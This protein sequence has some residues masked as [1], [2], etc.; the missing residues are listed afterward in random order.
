MNLVVDRRTRLLAIKKHLN[1]T[2]FDIGGET[3]VLEKEARQALDLEDAKKYYGAS[4]LQG[5]VRGF[6]VRIF[7]KELRR[8]LHALLILQ[9]VLRGKLGRMRWMREYW[10]SISVVKSLE[11][12]KELIKRST[13][14]RD[15]AQWKEYFDPMTE[16]FWYHEGK[17]NLSTWNVPL[18]FQKTLVCNWEGFHDYGGS[19]S[20]TRCRCIF[21]NVAEYHGHLRTA[22][23]WFCVSCFKCN[24]G[25]VFPRCALCG[26]SKSEDGKDGEKALQDSV[27]AVRNKVRLFLAKENSTKTGFK[28]KLR[29][30]LVS[31]AV[32]I[33]ARKN[34]NITTQQDEMKLP[35]NIFREKTDRLVPLSTSDKNSVTPAS[36]TMTSTAGNKARQ[37]K[38]VS[39]DPWEAG[40]DKRR[41]NILRM[42]GC[43]IPAQPLFGR[44]NNKECSPFNQFTSSIA[45]LAA[46]KFYE[47]ELGGIKGERKRFADP[48]E[49]KGEIPAPVFDWITNITLDDDVRLGV[50]DVELSVPADERSTNM[51]DASPLQQ[52]DSNNNV[53]VWE[54]DVGS[55][56]GDQEQNRMLV[57][58]LFLAGQ[59]SKS[60]CPRAHPGLR[61]RAQIFYIRL[62]GRAKKSPF[63]KC[64][65]QYSGGG[66]NCGCKE[67]SNCPFYHIYMRP[68]TQEIIRRIYPI[69]EG[70]KMKVLPSGAQI[71]GNL[72]DNQLSGYGVMTWLSGASYAGDW[73]NDVR[74]GFGIYRTLQ[75]TEY[76]GG[77]RDGKRH[78][79]GH[80][81]N[82]LGEEYIG[83]WAHG[84][85]EGAGVLSGANGDSYTG[86]FKGHKFHGVGTFVKPCGSIFT[87]HCVEGM[88]SGL[89]IMV[90][91]TGEK[92]KGNFD[93]N[94]RHGKGACSYPNGSFY[95]GEWYRGVPTGFG[96]FIAPNGEKFVGQ[97]AGGRKEG[98]GRYMFLDG[99][100][101]DGEFHKD[102]AKGMGLYYAA[103]GDA[104]SGEWDNDKRHGRGTY[105][106]ANGS[107]YTGNWVENNIHGKGKFDF[108]S[109]SH[110]RGEFRKN[111][112]HGRGIYTWPN[113]NIYKG[114]FV[115]E[116]M[117][118]KGEMTYIGGHR[119]TGDWFNSKKHG[120]GTFYYVTGAV[121][122][123]DWDND[124]RRG[125]GRLT[126]L[127]GSFIEEYYDGEWDDD[128][129]HG[130]GTYV[131]RKDEG[132]VYS[133]DWEKGHRHGNGK[134]AFADGSFYSGSFQSEKM[135]G[136]GLYVGADGSQYT[137]EWFDNMRQGTGTMLGSDGSI[138]HGL[139]H[140]NMKHGH[141]RLQ[142]PDGNI[143]EGEWC[144]NI[145]VGD[146]LSGRYTLV[147]G[148]G[149][150]GGPSEITMQ[151]FSY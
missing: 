59:C 108:A 55:S 121:Y 67:A 5:I 111:E 39:E 147:C 22:H 71:D 53:H 31:L 82:D 86:Q 28:F 105:K 68:S 112:K 90:L 97:F 75:G 145:I 102:R 12:L 77:W 98:P 119:Y 8:E 36:M 3:L 41:K 135:C 62:R 148:Q 79:M 64:C 107:V 42:T 73:K 130:K 7:C 100:F 23:K 124:V 133:G 32:D 137:G 101:Y 26:N 140:S 142:Y 132:T 128:E 87:G 63:I 106:F 45:E 95:V 138:Y 127:P 56:A 120:H 72:K 89:G 65:S 43:M 104:Y 25:A 27:A 70:A 19:T 37:K 96:V 116:R 24:S 6:L 94:F 136:H 110:Y 74:D 131:Y 99:S 17:S 103:N 141:G 81:I 40:N 9:R 151:V 84:K 78:G 144:G 125:N 129:K 16:A 30:R 123:G 114:Q 143:F 91:N 113:G 34:K 18:I 88:A 109:G 60:T 150:R 48:V 146:G 80:Y 21:D 46:D 44:E 57:C 11:A 61:D 93:R 15:S 83:E 149:S 51:T 69:Q 126:F 2:K 122:A 76:S 13:M 134:L 49:T 54:E 47:E 20:D 58:E 4:R 38:K 66:P 14:I 52:Q 117:C 1:Q 50:A 139:Y 92:Y 85:M 29:D 115:V 33:I 118:G 10:K 35:R